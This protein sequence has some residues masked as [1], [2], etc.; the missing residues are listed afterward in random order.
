MYSRFIIY[1]MQILQLCQ[2][3]NI[4]PTVINNTYLPTIKNCTPILINSFN[5]QMIKI[6]KT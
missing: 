1:C 3:E 5:T 2:K 4:V 6:G